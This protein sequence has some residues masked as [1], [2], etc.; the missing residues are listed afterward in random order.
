MP[1]QCLST[2]FRGENLYIAA[3]QNGLI[4]L[5][6]PQGTVICELTSHSR[7]INALVCHPSKS[8]FATCSDDTFVNIFEVSG[9]K[10]EKIDINLI[11]SSRVNDYMLCGVAFGGESNNSVV[12][13]PYDYKTVVIWNNIV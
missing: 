1:L 13:V 7:M 12:A 4:K 3:Y 6:S 2:L 5:L 11:V 9:D 10:V 8:V